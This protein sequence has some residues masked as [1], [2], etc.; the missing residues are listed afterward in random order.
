MH[1]VYV[2]AVLAIATWCLVYLVTDLVYE[3]WGHAVFMHLNGFALVYAITKF[4]GWRECFQ[5]LGLSLPTPIGDVPSSVPIDD[6]IIYTPI[7]QSGDAGLLVAQ[8]GE[9]MITPK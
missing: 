6:S 2:F 7:Q 3:R 4:M 8:A 1:S 5:D 9:E